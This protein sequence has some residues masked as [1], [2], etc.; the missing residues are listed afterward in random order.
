MMDMEVNVN[1]WVEWI[2]AFHDQQTLNP[3]PQTGRL[4][5]HSPDEVTG[6][7]DPDD[8]LVALEVANAWVSAQHGTTIHQNGFGENPLCDELTGKSGR[9]NPESKCRGQRVSVHG[10]SRHTS[11]PILLHPPAIMAL[12]GHPRVQL[13][14]QP[15]VKLKN[16]I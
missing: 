3:I 8:A 14:E 1:G 2:P 9:W 4:W 15:E 12:H 16:S 11:V 5:P 6:C 10:A 13:R 7:A